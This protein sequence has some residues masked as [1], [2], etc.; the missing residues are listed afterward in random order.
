LHSNGGYPLFW[1][2]RNQTQEWRGVVNLQ[3]EGVFGTWTVTG[4]IGGVHTTG[5]RQYI[6]V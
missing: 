1:M 4:S 2:P 6:T 3:R 5:W